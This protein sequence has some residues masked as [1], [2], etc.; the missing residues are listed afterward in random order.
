MIS[1]MFGRNV[2]NYII[3]VRLSLFM[4]VVFVVVVV[5]V[6]AVGGVVWEK[7][8]PFYKTAVSTL[9]G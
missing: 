7:R 4:F 6:V 5:V 2:V 9:A 8:E 1:C 3:W